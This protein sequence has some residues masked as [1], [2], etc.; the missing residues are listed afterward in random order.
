MVFGLF[1]DVPLLTGTFLL[2]LLFRKRVAF[3]IARI[4]LPTVVLSLL[5]SIPLIIFEEQ[6]DCQPSWC[7][8]VIIPPTLPFLLL[9]M[10]ILEAI[11]IFLHARSV[12]NVTIIFSI[13]GI[14]F[15]ILVGGLRGAPLLV[16]ILLIPYVGLGYAYISMLPLTVLLEGRTTIASVLVERGGLDG[17]HHDGINIAKTHYTYSDRQS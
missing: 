13:Y 15:E 14:V 9:E 1:I 17:S 8:R 11:A 16:T 12:R 10:L 3:A 6:I 4:A 5:T 7:G 2:L